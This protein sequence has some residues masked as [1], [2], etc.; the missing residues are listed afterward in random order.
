VVTAGAIFVN[1]A[2]WARVNSIVRLCAAFAHADHGLAGACWRRA[3][4]PLQAQHRG[5]SRSRSADGGDRHATSG[6]SAEEMERNVTI[7]IEVQMAGMPHLN[8]IRAIAVRPVGREGPVHLRLHLRTGAA[9]GDQP[10]V[11]DWARCRAASCRISP[12]SPIGEIFRYRIRAP[13][14]Y[15]VMDLKTLQDWV[16]ERRSRPFPA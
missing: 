4:L 16:L 1:E 6:L 13:K 2:G 15:S 7:P 8:T 14:G 12:T 11:A 9:A 10:P 3:A 5:L